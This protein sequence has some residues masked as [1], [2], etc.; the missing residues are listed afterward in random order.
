MYLGCLVK[1]LVANDYD[2]KFEQNPAR[3]V[4]ICE[5][6][7]GLK[8]HNSRHRFFKEVQIILIP[9]SSIS[10]EHAIEVARMWHGT[11]PKDETALSE[12][13]KSI[14]GI[15]EDS[16]PAAI[17]QYLIQQGYAVPL[18]FGLNHWASGKTAIELE[19]AIDK[20]TI[21]NNS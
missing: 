15:W 5:D 4:S 7:I 1:D 3:I 21:Q 10:D 2:K 17:H 6:G 11:L 16:L 9:L 13:G 12:Y 14:V 20:T 8:P 19:I 18:F